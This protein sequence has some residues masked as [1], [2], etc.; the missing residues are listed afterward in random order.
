MRGAEAAVS[1]RLCGPAAGNVAA[2]TA[3]CPSKL[4]P[5][6]ECAR[7]GMGKGT[8]GGGPVSPRGVPGVG[9]WGGRPAPA[10]LSGVG[11]VPAQRDPADH[12]VPEGE[13]PAP[14]T[15]HPAGGN[16]RVAQHRGQHRELRGGHQQRALGHGAAGHPVPQAA[17]QNPH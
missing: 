4:S 11:A 15:G 13:Q 8:G 12:A 7:G 1:V 5:R 9:E 3:R 2:A 16:H 10:V 6:S 17:R 14:G